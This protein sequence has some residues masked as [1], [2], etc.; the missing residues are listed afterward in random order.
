[1]VPCWE[2]SNAWIT[3]VLQGGICPPDSEIGGQ[4]LLTAAG[5]EQLG[6][7]KYLF[8]KNSLKKKATG[9]KGQNNHCSRYARDIESQGHWLCWSQLWED[10]ERSHWSKAWVCLQTP[11][12]V[13]DPPFLPV[14]KISVELPRLSGF[15]VDNKRGRGFLACPILSPFH[16][17]VPPF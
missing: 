4:D 17:T 8:L 13:H 15:W 11:P 16:F 2:K 1:M 7:E 14:L 9:S 5:L 3:G 12:Q 6:W 10:L